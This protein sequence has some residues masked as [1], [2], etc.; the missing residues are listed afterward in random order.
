I[1][2]D[3]FTKFTKNLS[4][5]FNSWSYESYSIFLKRNGV[6]VTQGWHWLAICQN[7]LSGLKLG[8]VS[9]AQLWDVV[10]LALWVFSLKVNK[11]GTRMEHKDLYPLSILAT[12]IFAEGEER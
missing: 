8:F 10:T 4:L 3:L 9:F 11:P 2:V 1:V 5:E 12:S 7:P 6:G